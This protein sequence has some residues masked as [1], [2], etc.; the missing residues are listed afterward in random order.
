MA[1]EISGLTF[2]SYKER[3]EFLKKRIEAD[4]AEIER[5]EYLQRKKR[6]MKK[7]PLG[8]VTSF[9]PEDLIDDD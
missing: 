2:M 9:Y 3:I 5:L 1:V 6:A 4:K 8:Y 7:K